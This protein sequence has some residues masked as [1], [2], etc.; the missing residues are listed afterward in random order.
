MRL[1]QPYRKLLLMS[2]AT[3]LTLQCESTI[4]S[5]SATSPSPDS[6][7]NAGASSLPGIP[8]GGRV[9]TNAY[10]PLR[11]PATQALIDLSTSFW[12][13]ASP[14]FGEHSSA[15]L[16]FTG[17]ATESG[18]SPSFSSG[19]REGYIQYNRGGFD[20]RVGKQ[21]VPWGKS[22]AINPTD[23]LTAKD[24]RVFNPDDEVRRL[25]SWSLLAS[26]VPDDGNSPLQFTFYLAPSFAQGQLLLASTV[27]P[28]SALA[29]LGS[30]VNVNL[31]P[32]SPE[33]NYGNMEVAFK[34]S[35]T[36]SR[37]D[38]SVS[39]YRGWNHTPFF[40]LER[41]TLTSPS[42]FQ[43]FL[44]PTYGRVFALG[45]DTSFNLSRFTFRAESSYIWTES[46]EGNRPWLQPGHWDT[47]AGAE[48]S[49]FGDFRVQLQGILRYYPTLNA[50]SMSVGSNAF[51]TALLQEVA[52]TNALILAFQ[53][54]V[55]PS[56]TLRLG[57]TH[58]SW[59]LDSE[60]FT[61]FNLIEG[62]FL[63]RP[64]LTYSL[65]DS[66][67]ATL[68]MDYYGGPLDRPFGSLADYRSIFLEG[69][70]SF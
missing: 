36:G 20:L 13:Q 33:V 39:A 10:L 16:I 8:L 51:E 65:T 5:V 11:N 69:K 46:T 63:F 60:L 59:G 26:F 22:D 29:P 14:K 47:V 1:V 31:T 68:G 43:A 6:L 4:A 57:Y 23:F 37:W 56:V 7:A 32:V 53:E 40:Q 41:F 34:T 35:V 9:F 15:S 19:L 17:K 2:L 55:R 64:K 70:M 66:I 42:T 44:S 3:V 52:K 49:F 18:T 30:Q 62:D 28:S 21:I 54:R 24:Y 12:L 38:L 45:M 67:K 50:A 61:W 48:T 58:D 25:G 27:A